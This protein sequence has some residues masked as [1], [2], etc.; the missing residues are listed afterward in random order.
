M[1]QCCREGYC[2]YGPATGILS[3]MYDV[4][5]ESYQTCLTGLM[6]SKV[7][8]RF[9][10]P[11]SLPGRVDFPIF[12]TVNPLRWWLL[13]LNCGARGQHLPAFM[14]GCLTISHMCFALSTY[15]KSVAILEVSICRWERGELGKM[16]KV[17]DWSEVTSWERCVRE[18]S[19]RWQVGKASGLV[20]STSD[21]R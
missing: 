8:S 9:G 13:R 10:D 18:V 3:W 11:W 16:G 19:V 14:S 1:L 21:S 20:I 5:G 7:G 6:G 12:D 2:G 17:Y 4:L 15:W